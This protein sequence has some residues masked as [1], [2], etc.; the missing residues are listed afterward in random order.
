MHVGMPITMR[1]LMNQRRGMTFWMKY[2]IIF[3][4]VSGSA[5]TPS[6]RGRMAIM[7]P[8]VFQSI[9]LASEPTAMTRL[10]PRSTATTEGSFM[11]IPL[12]RT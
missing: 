8:G 9:R 6:R 3:S 12:P 2:F 5:M 10:V 4:V 1:G 11:T 7:F